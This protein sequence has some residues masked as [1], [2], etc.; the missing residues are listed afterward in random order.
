MVFVEGIPIV[1]TY[2]SK[3]TGEVVPDLQMNVKNIQL[4]GGSNRQEPAQNRQQQT[5]NNQP[6]T[7]PQQTQPVSNQQPAS[8]PEWVQNQEVPF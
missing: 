6:A 3:K 1:K 4:L 2:V 5:Q 8:I 7:S